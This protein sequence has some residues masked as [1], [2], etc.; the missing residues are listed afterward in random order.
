MRWWKLK[1]IASNLSKTVGA[2]GYEVV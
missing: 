2:A 1:V